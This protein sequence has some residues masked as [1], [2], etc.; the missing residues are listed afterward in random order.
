MMADVAPANGPD[1]VA[2]LLRRHPVVDGH[3]DLL[4]ALRDLVGYDL[5]RYD[6]GQRQTRTHTDLPRLRDGGVGAQ[7]WSVFVP[8]QEGGAGGDVDAR[9]DR[10]GV[11]DGPTLRRPA[12]PRDHGRRRR[13]GV[14]RRVGSRA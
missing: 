3:N 13:G 2:D 12:R 8:T 7:F 5:D 11:R 4:W 10:R 14:G 1:P 6:V 9:A